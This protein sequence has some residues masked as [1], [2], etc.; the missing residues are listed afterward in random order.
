MVNLQRG[1]FTERWKAILDGYRHPLPHYGATEEEVL[2]EL[3][4]QGATLS[5]GI[6]AQWRVED[7][8]GK[9]L[10]NQENKIQSAAWTIPDD[11]FARAVQDLREWALQRCGSL[12]YILPQERQFK[13]VVVRNWA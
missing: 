3:Q 7:T 13:I 10:E 11:I 2:T 8:V 9:L 5:T 12:D 4:A 1:E 6:A